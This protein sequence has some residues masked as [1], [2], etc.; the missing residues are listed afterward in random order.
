[1]NHSEKVIFVS[2]GM[3]QAKK[4]FNPIAFEHTYLNYGLLGLASIIKDNKYDTTLL[5][6]KFEFPACFL[7]KFEVLFK[8]I[9]QFPLFISIP[10]YLALEWAID[11]VSILKNKYPDISIIVGG[12][13]VVMEDGDWIKKK[14]NNNIDLVVYGMSENRIV[15]LLNKQMWKSIAFTDLNN[16]KNITFDNNYPKFDYSLMPDYLEFT[17]SLDVS[18]GCGKGCH[19]CLER[20]IKQSKMKSPA[21]VIKELQYIQTIYQNSANP[22]F[23]ASHF[24]P[25]RSWV[26][27][28]YKLYTENSFS[29]KWRTETR[30]DTNIKDNIFF[31]SK[32]GLKILDIGLE[33]ASIQQL[34]NMGKSKNP[35]SYLEKA[36]LLL[37]TCKK[38]N[39]WTKI[40][41]LLYPGETHETINETKKWLLNYKKC[42]KGISINP[43][44][45]YKNNNQTDHYLN[46]LYLKYKAT[47][48]EN[49]I[50]E[51]GY[52][53]MNLSPELPFSSLTKI[54]TE[55]CQEFMSA[56]DYYD[57]K[58]FSYFNK[59][60]FSYDTFLVHC[61]TLDTSTLPFIL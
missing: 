33:S 34:L 55:F 49:S 19:F 43:L 25:D 18:R 6:G 17:P 44:T 26:E 38:N 7:D 22:Y 56:Q 5:H 3:L 51:K 50:D 29:I 16:K 23:E 48:I 12:R 10:S 24:N 40:N 27:E 47:P 9:K 61:N 42:I 46:E 32:S 8:Q 31:L 1:M 30:A 60:Q 57:L 37:E 58:S 13:W 36:G 54:C 20:K 52:C 4:K 21:E 53:N 59:T 14:F 28:F 11:F 45:V 41:I 15:Q 39:V 35:Q 2:S